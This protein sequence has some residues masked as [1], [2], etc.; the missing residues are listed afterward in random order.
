MSLARE[1]AIKFLRGEIDRPE[2]ERLRSEA[3]SA[4]QI[5]H[6]NVCQ[7]FEVGESYIVMAYAGRQ[8]LDQWSDEPGR[9]PYDIARMTAKVAD[10]IE[11]AHR[12]G[13]IHYDVKPSNILVREEDNQPIVVDFGLSVR[14]PPMWRA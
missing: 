8:T 11:A 13:I 7:V 2:R 12:R 4:A 9:N 5:H 10:G 14:G 1:E 3:Q 6:T